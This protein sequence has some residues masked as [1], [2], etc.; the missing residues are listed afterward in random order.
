M[1]VPWTWSNTWEREG[2]IRERLDR[3]LGSVSWVQKF[4]KATYEHVEK[5]TSD[6]CLLILDTNPQKI[7]VKRRF[8]F[9]QRWAK[10]KESDTIIKKAWGLEQHG[11]WMYRVV[12]SI[13]ECRLALIEW[14]KR[15]RSNAKVKIQEIKEKSKVAREGGDPCNRGDIACLKRQLS[16]AYKD[17]ERFWSQKSRSRWLKEGDKNIA[18]FHI[19]NIIKDDVVNAI[20]SFFHTG[21]LLRTV[22]ETIISLIPKVDNLVLL[23]NFRPISL[24]TVLYKTIS[25]VLANRL[26][27]VLKHCISPSQSAFVPGRQILDNVIIAHKFCIF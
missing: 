11:S 17:E 27:K 14:N 15:V 9:D 8:Y 22:N 20:S 25:K 4:E 16:K 7:R 2:E 21:N 3:C 23:T 24:C 5:Q 26:K 19:S 6:H 12:R 10:D 18:F 1:G 13:K